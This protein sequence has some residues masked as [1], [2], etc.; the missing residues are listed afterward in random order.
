MPRCLAPLIAVSLIIFLLPACAELDEPVTATTSQVAQPIINATSSPTLV[1]LSEGEE[2]AIG[3]LWHGGE[4]ICT[5]TLIDR[6]T[7]LT[8]QH[9]LDRDT[10]DEPDMTLVQQTQFR[11]GS[12]GNPL[13]SF[14]ISRASLAGW[15]HDIALLQL[16]QDAVSEV[17]GLEPISFNRLPVEDDWEGRRLEGAGYHHMSG[18]PHVRMYG[19]FQIRNVWENILVT[20]GDGSRALCP[21]DSGGPLLHQTAYGPV[22][23]AIHV[24]TDAGCDGDSYHSLVNTL[25]SWID[26]ERRWFTSD[27][28]GT[29]GVTSRYS[30]L[31]CS[32][33]PA[34]RT[35][36][37]GAWVALLLGATAV[38]RRRA[39]RA[40]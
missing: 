1:S 23:V 2:L 22:V 12:P 3:F 21:G 33:S 30:N 16:R 5:A 19:V 11:V 27:G 39:H 17:P 32:A 40:S 34:R 38:R 36:F 18:T 24:Q 8:A 31:L 14:D 20:H 29:G 37:P 6:D 35:A 28:R 25:T 7:V 13:G 15:E 26:D 4:A 9:C 10:D